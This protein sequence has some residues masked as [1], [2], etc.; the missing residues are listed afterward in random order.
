MHIFSISLDRKDLYSDGD[1]FALG[2]L[3]I[4]YFSED[5]RSSLSYW[6][7]NKYLSQW[8][9]ALKRLLNGERCSALV[10]TMY[11]PKNANFIFWWVMYLIGDD[12]HMQNH[13]LFLDELERQFDESELYSFIPE[14]EEQTEEGQPISEW[15]VKISAIK[16]FVDSL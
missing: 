13:V 12:V 10:T 8:R 2:S 5:F 3:K 6:D 15:V 9:E 1:L 11:D 14:R 16:G 4:G 7:R